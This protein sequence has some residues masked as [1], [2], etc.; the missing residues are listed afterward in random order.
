VFW[1]NF[2][3]KYGIT[4]APV[5]DLRNGFPLSV[6]DEDRNF[7]GQRNR[8]GRFPNF[9]S[10][11]LQVLKSVSAPGRFSENYRFRVGVKVF[12]LTNHFNPRDFQGNNASDEF[13][14]FYNGVGRKFGMKFVIEKK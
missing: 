7:V 11:D 2:T 5:L 14:G 1:G 13:G 9:T 3:V 6:I 12:N 10:L 4:V 8:A